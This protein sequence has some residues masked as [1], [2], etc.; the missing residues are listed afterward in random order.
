MEYPLFL[1]SLDIISV[2]I[3]F[4]MLFLLRP[5]RLNDQSMSDNRLVIWRVWRDHLPED[6]SITKSALGQFTWRVLGKLLVH[7]LHGV[8][9]SIGINSCRSISEGGLVVLTRRP[10]QLAIFGIEAICNTCAILKHNAP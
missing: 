5:H 8:N 1:T 4:S 7:I 9:I 6:M 3:G 10:N 2:D